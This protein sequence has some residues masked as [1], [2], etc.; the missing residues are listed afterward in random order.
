MSPG[1]KLHNLQL[2][3]SQGPLLTLLQL[4]DNFLVLQDW[5]LDTVPGCILMSTEKENCFHQ[6]RGYLPLNTT[7]AVVTCPCCQS[8]LLVHVQLATYPPTAPRASQQ[9]C[10]TVS[11]SPAHGVAR[12][13]CFLYLS[14]LNLRLVHISSFF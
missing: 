11:P 2:P 3:L 6:I 13:S 5:K 4:T 9:S 8:T 10:S 7:L 1:K 14:L 12:G